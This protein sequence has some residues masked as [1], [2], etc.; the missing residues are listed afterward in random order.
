MLEPLYHALR[1][2]PSFSLGIY[3]CVILL[4]DQPK[5]GAIEVDFDFLT[6]MQRIY[7]WTLG[8]QQPI[9]H[10]PGFEP[11]IVD[12]GPVASNSSEENLQAT[13]SKQ[14]STTFVPPSWYELCVMDWFQQ[15]FP[16]VSCPEE[17][18]YFENLK[19][20]LA[21]AG[22]K[23]EYLMYFGWDPQMIDRMCQSGCFPMA[24]YINF[25]RSM[26]LFISTIIIDPLLESSITYNHF[27][28]FFFSTL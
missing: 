10:I 7:N 15:K 16:F 13:P 17:F 4:E 21:N 6:G 5:E 26:N 18:N 28:F 12:D 25:D 2:S 20:R 27:F 14:H 24:T 1:D 22:Y 19:R 11:P 9:E 23:R 8:N 3:L